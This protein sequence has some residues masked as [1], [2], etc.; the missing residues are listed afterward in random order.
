MDDRLFTQVLGSSTS[1]RRRPDRRLPHYQVRVRL[2]RPHWYGVT[3]V[4]WQD[5]T[6]T[7][8]LADTR[9]ELVAMGAFNIKFTKEPTVELL[10]ERVVR[11]L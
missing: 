1:D 10:L 3:E 4:P 6:R 11:A 7:C 8:V 5:L 2:A 9:E